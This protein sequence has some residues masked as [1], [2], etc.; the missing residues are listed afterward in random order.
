MEGAVSRHALRERDRPDPSVTR[1]IDRSALRM[2][3]DHDSWGGGAG[4]GTQ[5]LVLSGRS[6]RFAFSDYRMV[7][8]ALLQPVIILLLFSQV[9]AGVGS[10]PGVVEYNGYINYLM[11]ATLVMIALTTA[12]SSGVAVLSEIYTGFIGRLRTMPIDLLAV[13]FAR[14]IADALRL[15][16]QLTAAAVGG[17]WLLGFEPAGPWPLTAAI[18]LAVAVGWGLSWV[19][20]ALATWQSKPEL[21]QAATFIVMFPLMFGSS[22]YMPLESMPTWIRIVSSVNPITYAIDAVR[23]LSLGRPA[24]PAVLAAIAIIA[25]AAALGA[26]AAKYLFTR[27]R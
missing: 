6:L 18:A 8:I 17:A 13:L 19:F 9:F 1:Y 10:M 27:T 25:A 14:T 26:G 23:A 22:A 12:M 20:I 4:F 5:L 7:L 16:V 11:P 3:S 2:T 15:A 21:M 24:G